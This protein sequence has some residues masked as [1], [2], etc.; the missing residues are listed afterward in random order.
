[1]CPVLWVGQTLKP[2][3]YL[4]VRRKLAAVLLAQH[5]YSGCQQH[6]AAAAELDA[7]E[8]DKEL[9]VSVLQKLQVTWPHL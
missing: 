8:A 9:L 3:R 4:Q 5:K 2:V 7:D 6:L 1:M